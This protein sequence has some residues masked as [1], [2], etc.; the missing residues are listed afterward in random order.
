MLSITYLVKVSKT[1]KHILKFS[2]EPKKRKYFCISALA[3]KKRSNE[4]N[5][6]TLCH[7]LEDFILTLILLFFHLTSFYR[8]G[9]KYKNIIQKY[10][11]SFFGAN[12][13][14]KICFRDLLTFSL[15]ILSNF[16]CTFWNSWRNLLSTEHF[17]RHN[18]GRKSSWLQLAFQKL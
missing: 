12:E 7:L 1:W 6:G 18:S 2:F 4:E 10:F 17:S 16:F 5:R 9:Q 15:L 11:L 8:L 14:F 13:N 3:S